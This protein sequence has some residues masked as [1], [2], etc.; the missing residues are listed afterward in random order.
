MI[1]SHVR[2]LMDEAEAIPM[3]LIRAGM[4]QGS[5]YNV[6]KDDF[7]IYHLK[8]LDLLCRFFAR[9]LNRT[10]TTQD[11]LEFVDDNEDNVNKS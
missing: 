5:A 4:A 10:I 2:E 8:T 6:V 1:I 7:E 11:I 3:D 9:R